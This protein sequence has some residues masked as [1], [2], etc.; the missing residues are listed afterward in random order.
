MLFS[1]CTEVK[2]EDAPKLVKITGR[3]MPRN[4]DTSTTISKPEIMG[5]HDRSCGTI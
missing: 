3:R 2:M 4:L 5:Q 1:A